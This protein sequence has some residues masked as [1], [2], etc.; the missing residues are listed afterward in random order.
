MMVLLER[1][2]PGIAEFDG[3][4]IP[5]WENPEEPWSILSQDGSGI[6]TQLSE[7]TKDQDG[8]FIHPSATIGENVRI[9]GPCY[10]GANV[11]IRHSAYLRGGSWICD[12]AVVGHCSEIK[13]SILLPNAK[14]PHFNYIGDSILGVGVNLGAGAKISNVRN[15]RREIMV[16]LRN[17]ERV[18]SGLKKMGAM[19]GDNS[20][21]GCN[22]VTNPGALLAPSS[23]VSPNQTVSG[24][25]ETKS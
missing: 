3:K 7:L 23:M 10:I 6:W 21:L 16:S 24:W 25:F 9:E 13:N 4:C 20:Q 2:F 15:D 1:L 19:I 12:D 8:V 22:V 18:N 14:A 11:D 5:A 17:G